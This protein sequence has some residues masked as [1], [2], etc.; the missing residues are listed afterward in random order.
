MAK[1]RG[2]YRTLSYYRD[3]KTEREIHG[4]KRRPDGRFYA[5]E[6]PTKTFGTN[7]LEAIRKFRAWEAERTKKI[8]PV[9][10]PP[11]PVADAVE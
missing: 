11:K 3:P 10:T 6:H 5:A 8:I 7:P 4:L 1:K 2:P 9:F